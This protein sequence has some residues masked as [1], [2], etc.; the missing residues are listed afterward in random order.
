MNED[1]QV[2]F[3]A[4]LTGT[5]NSGISVADRSITSKVALAGKGGSIPGNFGL[6]SS[7]SIARDNTPA[8]TGGVFSSLN[9]FAIN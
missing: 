8:P 7:P 5:S 4:S 9:G 2:A 1:G 6:V 3:D